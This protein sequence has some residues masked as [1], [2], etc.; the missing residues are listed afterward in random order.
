MSI[1]GVFF[2][3]VFSYEEFLAVVKRLDP[4]ITQ[5]NA[6]RMFREA[7]QQSGAYS[8]TKEVFYTVCKKYGLVH[9]LDIKYVES[10][11]MHQAQPPE[12]SSVPSSTLS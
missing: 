8:M 9:L 4:D 6:A 1:M 2:A 7:Y 10:M 3:G 5:N 11:A 12:T